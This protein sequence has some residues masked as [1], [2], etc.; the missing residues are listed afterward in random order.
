MADVTSIQT[1]AT[2]LLTLQLTRRLARSM[3]GKRECLLKP[4]STPEEAASLLC[5][6][7]LNQTNRRFSHK[8]PQRKG[9]LRHLLM[10]PAGFLWHY[11]Q[12]HLLCIIISLFLDRKINSGGFAALLALW[13]LN[14]LILLIRLTVFE[15]TQQPFYLFEQS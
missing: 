10:L 1:V 4:P 7:K 3:K 9:P 8:K 14:S 11:C 13:S 15:Q 12:K 6:M 2:L 5:N